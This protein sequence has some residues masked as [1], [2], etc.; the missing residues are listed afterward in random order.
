LNVVSCK[1]VWELQKRTFWV[2]AVLLGFYLIIGFWAEVWNPF[3]LIA[4]ALIYKKY[5]GGLKR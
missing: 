1:K 5:G 4:T 2:G 3:V